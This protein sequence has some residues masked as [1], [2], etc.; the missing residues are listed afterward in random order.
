MKVIAIGGGTGLSTILRGLKEKNLELT[1]VV[2]V[3][4]E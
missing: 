2:A 4:D 1:A 3:T